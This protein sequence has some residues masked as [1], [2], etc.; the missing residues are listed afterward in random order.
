MQTGAQ[1]PRK[2]WTVE[3]WRRLRGL[4]LALAVL[5]GI[6]CSSLK[7]SGTSPPGIDPSSA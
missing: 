1:L 5:L 2:A 6:A 7:G 4:V 3:I